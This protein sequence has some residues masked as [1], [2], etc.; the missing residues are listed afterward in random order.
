MCKDEWLDIL[1]KRIDSLS[2][3]VLP[4]GLSFFLSRRAQA[5]TDARLKAE[6]P[7][8]SRDF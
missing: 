5:T 2:F 4:E 1:A 3:N 7:A 6:V 8:S